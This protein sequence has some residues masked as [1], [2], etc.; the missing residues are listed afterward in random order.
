M[1]Q[2]RKIYKRKKKT[3]KKEKKAIL[4]TGGGVCPQPLLGI[5]DVSAFPC[6]RHWSLGTCTSAQIIL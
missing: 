2:K 1:V 6:K 3:A 5:R 4:M